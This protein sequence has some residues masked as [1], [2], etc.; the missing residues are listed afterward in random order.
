[1]KKVSIEIKELSQIHTCKLGGHPGILDKGTAVVRT[2][3]SFHIS[4]LKARAEGKV[5][6]RTVEKI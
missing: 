6:G 4:I 2:E 1:M 3:G 5:K